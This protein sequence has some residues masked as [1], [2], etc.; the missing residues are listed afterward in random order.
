MVIVGAARQR[1]RSLLEAE[2]KEG[3]RGPGRPPN[4]A[5]HL[6]EAGAAE[7]SARSALPSVT[8]QL[9]AVQ[10]AIR[11]VSRA[12]HAVDLRSGVRRSADVVEAEVCAACA[13]ID[14]VSTGSSLGEKN[15]RIIA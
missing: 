5:R 3:R 6:A 11:T 10:E 8:I 1:A 12:Y 2:G 9:E 7:G 4:F 14:R 15:L 13:I